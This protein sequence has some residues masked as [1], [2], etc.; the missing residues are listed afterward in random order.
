MDIYSFTS[1]W[2]SEILNVNPYLKG[3]KQQNG[4]KEKYIFTCLRC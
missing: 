4:N 2:L 1:H 3:K